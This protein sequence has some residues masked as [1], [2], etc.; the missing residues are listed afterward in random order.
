MFF[1]SGW[2]SRLQEGWGGG[3]ISVPALRIKL[4]SKGQVAYLMTALVRHTEH[5][6]SQ[7]HGLAWCF[8]VLTWIWQQEGEEKRLVWDLEAQSQVEGQTGNE[9]LALPPPPVPQL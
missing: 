7:A 6:T 2:P 3:S 8:K 4:A 9:H 1:L 5:W